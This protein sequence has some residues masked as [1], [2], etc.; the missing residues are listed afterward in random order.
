MSK[1]NCL[2]FGT[3]RCP[4]YDGVITKCPHKSPPADCMNL[5]DHEAYVFLG[6]G[7]FRREKF[8]EDNEK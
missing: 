4:E 5:K 8:M 6:D 1:G 3:S 7:N 2:Y